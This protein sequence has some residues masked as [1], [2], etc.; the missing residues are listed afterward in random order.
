AIDLRHPT[1]GPVDVLLRPEQITLRA[2][3]DDTSAGGGPA[4]VELV[5]FYGHDSVVMV[6][7]DDGTELRIRVAGA[8]RV[9]RGD[10][11]E[12]APTAAPTF[13][14]P[15]GEQTTTVSTVSAVASD[16]DPS[17]A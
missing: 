15:G 4:T 6:R 7:L 5:E 13:A 14:F 17:S 16:A 1:R 12:V 9:H 3:R 2:A 11:V 8:P 10:A